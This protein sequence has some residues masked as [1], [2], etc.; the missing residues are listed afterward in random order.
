MK[1]LFFFLML[2]HLKPSSLEALWPQMELVFNGLR[3]V[4]VLMILLLYLLQKRLPSK[5]VWY[6]AALQGWLLFATFLRRRE[7]LYHAVMIIISI[8]AVTLLIDLFSNNAWSMTGGLMLNMELLIYANLISVLMYYPAGMYDYSCYFLGYH[9]SFILYVLPAIA[10]A[11]LY[12]RTTGA[13]GRPVLLIS[14]GCLSVFITWSATSVC[15]LAVFGL[16]LLLGRTKLRSWITFPRILTVTLAID[17]FISVF[18][19]MNRAA[20]VAWIIESL[21]HKQVTLTGRTDLWDKFYRLFEKSPWVGYGIAA[22]V[23]KGTGLT[24]HN[25][26]FH[27]LLEGGIIGLVLFLLFNIVVG[28][29]LTRRQNSRNVFIF[30]GAFAALYT[31]FIADVYMGSPWFFALYVLAYH[32]DRFEAVPARPKRRLRIVI[33]RGCHVPNR[34]LP[35]KY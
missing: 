4:S 27:F 17:L 32:I 7:Y 3:A 23:M 11:L 2:P 22:E 14:A 6:V 1:W 29:R 13:R 19:V 8:I 28:R 26:W 21:L 16:V 9:N 24:A 34:K 20:W 31:I 5:A 10:I 12:M 18:R 30:Y 15:G 25:Q 35:Q 33:K